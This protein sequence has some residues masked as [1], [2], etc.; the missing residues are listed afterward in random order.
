MPFRFLLLQRT[1]N[2]GLEISKV[3]WRWTQREM[4]TSSRCIKVDQLDQVKKYLTFLITMV[5]L[6]DAEIKH[7]IYIHVNLFT[8]YYQWYYYF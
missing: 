4:Q 6:Q 1:S 2:N 3:R 8:F 7:I 5:V